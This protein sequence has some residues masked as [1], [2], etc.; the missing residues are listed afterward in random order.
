[1]YTV[2][3]SATGVTKIATANAGTGPG[4]WYLVFT[5]NTNSVGTAWNGSVVL[6]QDLNAPGS[7]PQ[8]MVAANLTTVGYYNPS[9]GATV[10]PGTAITGTGNWQVGL[11]GFD[12]YLNHTL[13][14][15]G[16]TVTVS[17]MPAS[18]LTTEPVTG[19]L[20]ANN[21]PSSNS[22][23]KIPPKTEVSK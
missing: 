12:L 16:T 1:M 4:G 2:T 8:P 20:T 15:A 19:F 9:T 10:A 7:V 17:L 14:T 23:S 13:T 18:A 21:P 22:M 6:G 5:G 3:L 11:T